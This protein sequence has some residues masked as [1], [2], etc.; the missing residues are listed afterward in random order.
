MSGSAVDQNDSDASPILTAVDDRG[1]YTSF[2]CRSASF[3]NLYLKH[4]FPPKRLQHP[5]SPLH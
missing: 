5:Q 1:S 3:Q 4:L 2:S